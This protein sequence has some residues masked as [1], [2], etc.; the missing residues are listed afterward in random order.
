[1]TWF[2]AGAVKIVGAASAAALLSVGLAGVIAQAAPNQA[3][4]SVSSVSK[5][6]AKDH[7]DRRAIAKAVFESEAEALG[8]TP[9]ILKADLKNGQKVSDLAK[10]LTKEQF[11]AKLLD[12]LKPRLKTLVDT[13]VITQPQADKAIDRISKGHVPF[14]NGKH[15]RTK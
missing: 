12:K 10:P 1:M 8:I 3:A 2:A 6:P 11:A 5:A 4:T 15:H 14:W 13:H 9:A 7:A